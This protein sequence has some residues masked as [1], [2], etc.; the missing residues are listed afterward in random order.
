MT[1]LAEILVEYFTA[2]QTLVTP[3]PVFQGAPH[4]GRTDIVLPA[5]AFQWREETQVMPRITQSQDNMHQEVVQL[6]G[7]A[8]SELALWGVVDTLRTIKGLNST[9]SA[10]FQYG[11][12]RR[13]N[14]S[15]ANNQTLLSFAVILDI[16][17]L[18]R[19]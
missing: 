10:A 4:L 14:L 2:V 16:Q 19:A 9:P 3:L 17:V 6:Y 5:L 13:T 11:P 7:A 12:I 1:T 18:W 8:A 15:F